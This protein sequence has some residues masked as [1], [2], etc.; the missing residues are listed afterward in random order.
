M[1]ITRSRFI[2]RTGAG[3]DPAASSAT[4]ARK[5]GTAQPGQSCPD[6]A[7]SDRPPDLQV[8]ALFVRPPG[9]ADEGRRRPF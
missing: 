4:G 3:T 6:R 5:A 8:L 9:A 2:G 1:A 7:G